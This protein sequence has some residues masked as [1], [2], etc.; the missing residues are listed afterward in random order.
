MILCRKDWIKEAMTGKRGAMRTGLII[1]G[2]GMRG[3]FS[4]GILK[5]LADEQ[6]EFPYAIGISSGSLNLLAFAHDMDKAS[7]LFFEGDRKGFLRLRNLRHPSRGLLDTDRFFER[8]PDAYP[9]LENISPDWH[10]AAVRAET[11]EIVYWPL[12]SFRD[13]EE[14][15]D[16]IRASASIP[17]LMPRAYIGG[18]VYVD[19]GIIDSIPIRKVLDDGVQ[20]AV[21]ILTRKKGY[22]KRKQTIGLYLRRWLKP[23]PQLRKAMETRH[24]R[25]NQA[26]EQ[27]ERLEEQGRIFVFRPEV[28]RL[29]RMQYDQAKAEQTYLDGVAIAERRL[30]ELKAYLES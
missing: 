15:C 11:A 1:E 26:L 25:Y 22:R 4:A 6:L 13:G 17:V 10:I 24:E 3:F 8:V 2:G 16:H 20:K 18:D 27:V 19:G 21:L 14:L 12:G 28:H 23:Y 5:V 9:W 29:G 30:T 7:P